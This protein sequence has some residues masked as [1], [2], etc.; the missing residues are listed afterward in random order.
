MKPSTIAAFPY[1]CHVCEVEVDPELGTVEIVGYVAVDD[2][3]RAV[4][5]LIIDGQIHGGIAQGVGQALLRAVLL[6][7]RHRAAA[8][9]IVH[10]LRDAAGGLLSVF[11]DGDQRSAFDDAPARHASRPARAAR[12]RRSAW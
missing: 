2:V 9:G 7:S 8:L 5:P 4:N 11:H 1:G 3:G 12:P 10:G 6:R